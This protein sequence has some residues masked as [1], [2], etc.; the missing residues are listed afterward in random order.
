[1]FA[2]FLKSPRVPWSYSLAVQM[3][4]VYEFWIWVVFVT[5]GSAKF[6]YVCQFQD[7]LRTRVIS[8]LALSMLVCH[9]APGSKSTSLRG[10]ISVFTVCCLHRKSPHRPVELSAVDPRTVLCRSVQMRSQ[11]SMLSASI[12]ITLVFPLESRNDCNKPSSVS[13][14]TCNG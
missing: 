7:Q 9:G 10:T 2:N 5:F 1:M 6:K 11:T 4:S 8:M 14:R 3:F 12:E 13:T